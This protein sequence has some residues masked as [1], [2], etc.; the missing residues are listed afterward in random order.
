MVYL[1]NA[2]GG[3]ENSYNYGYEYGYGNSESFDALKG[4]PTINLTLKKI[5]E[6]ILQISLNLIHKIRLLKHK[7]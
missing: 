1:L 5:Y 3:S 4:K 6:N 7:F 2:A